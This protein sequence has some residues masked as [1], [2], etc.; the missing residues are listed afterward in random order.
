MFRCS[1]GVLFHVTFVI[2]LSRDLKNPALIETNV[3]IPSGCLHSSIGPLRKNGSFWRADFS[4]LMPHFRGG[5]MA[6]NPTVAYFCLFGVRND[7]VVNARN[8]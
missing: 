2:G 7:L 5:L 4:L 8:G 1:P 3:E 6:A